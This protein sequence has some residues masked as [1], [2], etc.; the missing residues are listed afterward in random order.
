MLC[1]SPADCQCIPVHPIRVHTEHFQDWSAMAASVFGS[2]QVS[3]FKAFIY[4]QSTGI[5]KA[6]FFLF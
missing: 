2:V 6:H 3:F 1:R 4:L 5:S